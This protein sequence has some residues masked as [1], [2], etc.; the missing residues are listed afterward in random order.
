V[1]LAGLVT[2]FALL[3]PDF[4]NIAKQAGLTDIFPNGGTV[5][6]QFIIETTGSGIG[7]ID[8]DNDGL[9]DLFVLSG[10]GGTNR[11]YHNEGN[12]MFRDVTDALGLR[13]SGWAEGVCAGDYDNDGFTDLFVTY[14]GANHLYRNIQ[15]KRF[16]DVTAAA[17]LTQNRVRYNTGCTFLDIDGDGHLDLFIANYLKFDPGTTPKPGANPYCF[18]RGIAVNCGPRGLPFDRN[19]FVPEQREWHVYRHL[20][21]VRHC[22]AGGPLRAWGVDGRLQRR[23]SSGH[24]CGL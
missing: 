23:W 5:T 11:M 9:L 24:L 7:F 20:R 15:G 1:K 22:R 6:K 16:E 12:G 21:A 19:I 3:A 13:S 17:H 8:Y 14:W 4:R 10:Q 2:I 18:Y